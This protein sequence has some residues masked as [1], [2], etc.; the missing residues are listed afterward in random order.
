MLNPSDSSCV[1][2]ENTK[3]TLVADWTSLDFVDT[4]D[5]RNK[6][7]QVSESLINSLK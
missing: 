7:M 5:E 1:S 2:N 3:V 6:L 4:I